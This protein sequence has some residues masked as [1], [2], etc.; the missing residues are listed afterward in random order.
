[1]FRQVPVLPVVVPIAAAVFLALLWSLRRRHRL[2]VPRT[3]LA[4]ALCVYVAGVTANTVFPVFLDKPTGDVPLSAFL[5]LVPVVGYEVSDAVQNVVIFIP[6]GVMVSLVLA[7]PS[8]RRTLAAAIAV[9]LAIEVTQYV[10]A[11]TLAGGHVA[12]VNDLLSN[13]VGGAVGIG[14]LSLLERSPAIGRALDRF[15]WR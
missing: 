15:R 9:S 4:A 2:S 3:V 13:A 6:V 14:L 7:R 10:T 11:H 5:N 1:M 12:D 8:W